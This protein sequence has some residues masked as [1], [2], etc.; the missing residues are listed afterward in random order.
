MRKGIVDGGGGGESSSLNSFL[1]SDDGFLSHS[2]RDDCG[3]VVVKL[4][5]GDVT[6]S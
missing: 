3:M 6:N 1:V 4:H 5:L 2:I